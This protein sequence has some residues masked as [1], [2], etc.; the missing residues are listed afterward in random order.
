MRPLEDHEIRE[1]LS[2]DVVAHLSTIDAQGYPHV[3]PIW[4]LA[5]DERIYLT[6]Y[7]SRPHLARIMR[8]PKVG[9]VIDIEAELRADG[10]RPN[11]QVRLIGD[12][13]V[14]VDPDEI[15]T[16]RIRAKYIGGSVTP[17]TVERTASLGRRLIEITPRA[18][19][20]VASI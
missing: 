16:Q 3:T 6:S 13:T 1:I 17:G 5:Y 7:P 4:F 12:A 15:W 8:N 2:L 10:E 9:F 11:K 14:S 20:A 19:T 18:I